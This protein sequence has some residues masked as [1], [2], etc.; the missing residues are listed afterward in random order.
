[1]SFLSFLPGD[2]FSYAVDGHPV[3][4]TVEPWAQGPGI[5]QPSNCAKCFHPHFLED[6]ERRFGVAGQLGCV[7]EKRL[8]HQGDKIRKSVW[9]AGLAA[10]YDPFV[11]RSTRPV[12]RIHFVSNVEGE[13][14]KVQIS[15]CPA[16]ILYST[17]AEAIF[18]WDAECDLYCRMCAMAYG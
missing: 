11:V 14:S 18:G 12:Q 8:L 10:E 1:M 2:V 5:L 7:V 4:D 13:A 15:R 17:R 16:K 9:F 6:V 3:R